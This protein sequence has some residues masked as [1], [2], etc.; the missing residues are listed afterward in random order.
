MPNGPNSP[1]CGSQSAKVADTRSA[2]PDARVATVR[3]ARPASGIEGGGSTTFADS[4]TRRRP[5]G[6]FGVLGPRPP[7]AG[8]RAQSSL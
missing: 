1:L 7:R 3:A 4:E 2:G 5:V 6:P 8:L